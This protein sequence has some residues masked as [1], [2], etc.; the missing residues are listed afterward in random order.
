MSQS[1]F[2]TYL[3]NENNYQAMMEVCHVLLCG[4][5]ISS[6]LLFARPQPI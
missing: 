6:L 2:T 3:W 5:P 1:D 4:N